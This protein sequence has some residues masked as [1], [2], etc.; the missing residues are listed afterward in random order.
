MSGTGNVRGRPATPSQISTPAAMTVPVP[1]LENCAAK[2]SPDC[3]VP[4]PD[5]PDPPIFMMMRG[6]RVSRKPKPTEPVTADMAIVEKAVAEA[7]EMMSRGSTKI[8]AA[9]A[10][11]RQLENHPQDVVVRA[12]I[13]GAGLTDR[14]ALTYWYNCRRKR[15]RERPGV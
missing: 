7:R 2:S 4:S 3:V 14:G 11:F 10:M 8:D 5:C 12:F 13:D 6:N 9:M 1:S 15:S